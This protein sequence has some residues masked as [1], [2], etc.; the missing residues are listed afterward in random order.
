M[1]QTERR[2]AKQRIQLKVID[3]AT[4]EEHVSGD[5]VVVRD[6]VLIAVVLQQ[7]VF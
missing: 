2:S 3:V 4:G 1:A 7:D 5:I 6:F